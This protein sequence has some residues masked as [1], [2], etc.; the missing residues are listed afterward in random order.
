MKENEFLETYI[1]ENKEKKTIIYVHGTSF[2]AWCWKE[3]FI[4]YFERKGYGTCCFSLRGHG[5]SW[6]KKRIN[7]FGINDYIKDCWNIIQK[8]DNSGIII[9]HS[10]GCIVILKLL[11]LFPDI[12]SKIV[13]LAP[14][15]NRGMLKNYGKI[16]I[17]RATLKKM[18]S[19]YFSERL[20]ENDIKK[21]EKK[22]AGIS[23]KVSFQLIKSFTLPILLDNKNV[24]IIGSYADKGVGINNLYTMGNDLNAITVIFPNICHAM[25]LDPEWKVIADTILNF[26]ENNGR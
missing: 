23:A 1:N 26:I 21:Y 9:A 20:N 16:F 8:L 24:M 10:V 25:M 13:L 4:P 7:K 2:G 6:G 5:E 15:T 12:S 18:S 14:A 3:Y 17:Q 22:F 19:I 11:A